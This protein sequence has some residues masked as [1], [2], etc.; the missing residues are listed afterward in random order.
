LYV[1]LD[2]QRDWLKYEKDSR[3][4]DIFNDIEQLKARIQESQEKIFNVR[5]K[6]PQLFQQALAT[7]EVQ[8]LVENIVTLINKC[9]E[10]IADN[11]SIAQG[12]QERLKAELQELAD[13]ARWYDALRPQ[14]Q[15]RYV[16]EKQ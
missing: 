9:V 15:P 13:G 14:A 2:R 12:K 11:E 1:L 7:L 6:N 3:I 4:L 8:R 16:D 5:Q 10:V